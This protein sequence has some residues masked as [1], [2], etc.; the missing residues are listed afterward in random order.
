LL[1]QLRIEKIITPPGSKRTGIF[2][3]H[4]LTTK[5]P[6]NMKQYYDKYTDEDRL[7][8]STLFRR[9]MENLRSRGSD[10]FFKA[11]ERVEFRA[12]KI[13]D[14]REL[15]DILKNTTGWSMEV[16]PN[17]IPQKDFFQLLA[18]KKFPATT[19]LRTMKQLDYLEEPD[20]FHDVFGHVP[21]L[22]NE[23]YTG[24]FT[25]I[26]NLALKH[27][28]NPRAIE[29][30]GRI[31]WFTIEF[32]LIREKGQLK[33]YG[34][35]IMSSSGETIYSLSSTPQHLPFQV[36]EIMRTA[37]RT[38]VFQEKYFIIDSMEALFSSLPEVEA[39]LE[40]ELA[41]VQAK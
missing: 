22:S 34:A 4:F 40:Q 19:W 21:L 9:Q 23:A 14:F 39:I 41:G 8:W 35:G 17:I 37:F 26:A 27:I 13:P 2:F 30:L 25:G 10:A 16:V 5:Q 31:Y 18:Q 33:V 20:M 3:A 36:E 32:G 6:N 28:D 12:E 24:F 7:V 38:D 29:L 1:S 11:L 15:D